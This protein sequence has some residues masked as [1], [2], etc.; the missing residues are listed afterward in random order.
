MLKLIIFDLDRTLFDWDRTQ[1]FATEK[2]NQWLKP[3]CDPVKFW[4]Y[5]QLEHDIIRQ[6][7]SVEVYRIA[8]YLR[9]LQRLGSNDLEFAK[10]LN[11]CFVQHALTSDLFCPAA[12]YV[13]D[14]CKKLDVKMVLLTNG[15]SQG[16]YLKI[17]NLNLD[18]W[19]DAYFVSEEQGISKP[20][21]QAFLNICQKFDIQP[22]ESLMVGDDLELDIL[23]AYD[24]GMQ[25]YWVSSEQKEYKH[26]S[27]YELVQLPKLIHTEFD[28]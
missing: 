14:Q 3:Y 15:L 24:L 10:Q 19:F 11:Q 17:K 26:L 25:V 2:V 7:F 22:Q 20:A 23:P 4:Q 6:R 12:E 16:Q 28:F 5:Y 27:T 8:R 9:P 1:E 18:R 13:L 21:P